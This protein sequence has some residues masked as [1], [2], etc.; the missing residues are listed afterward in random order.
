MLEVQHTCD[1]S[2]SMRFFC[3][4]TS[5][6]CMKDLAKTGQMCRRSSGCNVCS[7]FSIHL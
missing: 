4:R 1:L 3:R 7:R 6:N 2:V 5:V